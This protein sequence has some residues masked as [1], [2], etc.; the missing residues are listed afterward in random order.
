MRS[1]ALSLC[2]RPRCVTHY[3]RKDTLQVSFWVNGVGLTD[4]GEIDR[5]YTASVTLR[6]AAGDFVELRS[7]GSAI[8]GRRTQGWVSWFSGF[9]VY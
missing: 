6:L 1:F 8:G 5:D 4:V 3:C 9:R 2:T 7:K